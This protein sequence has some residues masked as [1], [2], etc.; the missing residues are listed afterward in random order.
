MARLSKLW[1]N[2]SVK[3][4]TSMILSVYGTSNYRQNFLTICLRNISTFIELWA[5]SWDRIFDP[6]QEDKKGKIT[7]YP[8][9]MEKKF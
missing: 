2:S 8:G 4:V 7:K 6:W 1:W 5:S 3:I 9:D